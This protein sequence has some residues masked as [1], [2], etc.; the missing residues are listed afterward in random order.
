MGNYII[1][2]ESRAVPGGDEEFNLWYENVHIPDVL[3]VPGFMSCTRYHIVDP[4]APQQRYM[5]AYSVSCDDPHKLL[6]QLFA[7]SQQMV[8]SSA[9]DQSHVV[10]TIY[11]PR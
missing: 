5:A 6:E 7:A 10:V 4:V 2:F 8:L 11:E 1:Q 3:A 9:L